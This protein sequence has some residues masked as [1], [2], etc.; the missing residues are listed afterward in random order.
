M[1]M[2]T[3]ALSAALIAIV[4]ATTGAYGQSAQDLSSAS[5]A[6]KGPA[7]S[8]DARRAAFDGADKNH[9]G[10]LDLAEFAAT[11]PPPANT[12]AESLFK[13]RDANQDGFISR[14]EYLAPPKPGPGSVAGKSAG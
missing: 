6:A 7:L 11:I 13:T 12:S 2:R 9:D 5:A 1:A 10:K 14:E 8:V 4:A 3:L